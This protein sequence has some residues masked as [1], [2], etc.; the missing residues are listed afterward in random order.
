MNLYQA[1]EGRKKYLPEKKVKFWIYQTLKALETMH[2]KGIFHRD[3]KPANI[4]MNSEGQ[5]KLGDFN[6]SALI[7][8]EKAKNFTNDSIKEQQLLNIGTQVGSG[9]FQAPEVRDIEN[10]DSLYDDKVDI[11]SMGITFCSLAFY[12]TEIPSNAYKLY[13]RE[14]VDIIRRMIDTNKYKRPNSA[15]IYNDFI[16]SYVEKVQQQIMFSEKSWGTYKVIDV[17]DDSLTNM[18]TMKAGNRMQ[19]HSHD[20]RDEVWTIISGTGVTV[21]DGM[22]QSVKP[23]DVIT[24]EAD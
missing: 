2:K 7:N 6:V 9:I 20:F 17:Q 15:T 16:K 14:L 21:I 23:G 24:I 4:L 10:E 1:I 18:L 3:I 22:R 19:Y 13:S 12:R 11:Y 5:V 8:I